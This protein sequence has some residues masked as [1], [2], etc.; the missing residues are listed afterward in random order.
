M[1]RKA[2]LLLALVL[3]A[4]FALALEKGDIIESGAFVNGTLSAGF[5]LNDSAIF[6][7]S[8]TPLKMT[9]AVNNTYGEALRVFLAVKQDDSWEAVEELGTVPARGSAVLEY[10]AS[11]EYSGATT[12]NSEFA[13]IAETPNGFVGRTFSVEEQWGTYEGY[14]KSGLYGVGVFVVPILGG[15]LIAL[16]VTALFAAFGR[17]H[18]PGE[19]DEYTLRTLFFPHVRGRPVGEILADLIINPR[20]LALRAWVRTAAGAAHPAFLARLHKPG[21]IAHNLR[22]WR[23]NLLANALRLPDARVAA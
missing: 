23:R 8:P 6:T 10:N 1:E 13:L 9:F 5:S 17:H 14:L 16:L 19:G 7:Q 2:L 20:I 22:P 21:D 15:L 18:K 3:A 12:Q 11:F 4:P